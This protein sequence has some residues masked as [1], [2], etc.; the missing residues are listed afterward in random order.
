MT[1]RCQMAPAQEKC[2]NLVQNKIESLLLHLH[3]YIFFMALFS[4]F[5]RSP[6]L[7]HNGYHTLQMLREVHGAAVRQMLLK[8]HRAI[9]RAVPRTVAISRPDRQR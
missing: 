9:A 3:R 5:V 7:Q 8:V 4:S 2:K 1:M 6:T